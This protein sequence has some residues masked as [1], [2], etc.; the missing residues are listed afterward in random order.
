MQLS[1]GERQRI[2]LA[3]AFIKNAPVLIL[4]E[5]TSSVD[6]RTEAQI[7]EALERLMEGRT[8]FV[9]THRL[10]ALKTCD[11]ILHIEKGRLVDFS[12]DKDYNFLELKKKALLYEK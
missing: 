12:R 4:D 7:I 10:D 1:G 3:R 2:S 8:T 11:V 9:I 5:P 6:I